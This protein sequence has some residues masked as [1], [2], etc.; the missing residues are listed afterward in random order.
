MLKGYA[1]IMPYIFQMMEANWSQNWVWDLFIPA[2]AG[3]CCV[4]GLTPAGGSHHWV[5]EPGPRPGW[6]SIQRREWLSS[7]TTSPSHWLSPHTTQTQ[8][9]AQHFYGR[10]GGQWGGKP[11]HNSIWK[12]NNDMIVKLIVWWFYETFIWYLQEVEMRSWNSLE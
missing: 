10:P 12:E 11:L 9:G 1:R 4:G 2:R 3:L 6:G 8:A 5:P 7:G